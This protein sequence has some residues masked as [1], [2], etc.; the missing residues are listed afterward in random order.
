MLVGLFVV[1]VISLLAV[2]YYFYFHIKV[3]SAQD[4]NR[5]GLMDIKLYNTYLRK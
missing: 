2:C 5:S 1:L 4:W 3:E